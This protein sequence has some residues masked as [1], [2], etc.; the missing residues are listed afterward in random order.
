[1]SVWVRDTVTVTSV[2]L[3]ASGGG[4]FGA[5]VQR[6]SKRKTSSLKAWSSEE[7]RKL[8]LITV[9]A[10]VVANL[11]T[12][13]FV[14]LAIAIARNYPAHP[15]G[16][17]KDSGYLNEAIQVIFLW[18]LIYIVQYANKDASTAPK[19]PLSATRKKWLDQLNK[20]GPA[21]NRM[22]VY[23]KVLAGFLT[24]LYLFALVGSAAGIK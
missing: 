23:A 18:I 5:R 13:L 9:T 20:L 8:L 16:T 10:T 1:M 15:P 2:L 17:P 19:D 21:M 11:I 3:V 22:L 14:G 12:V 24:L 7:T 6:W 4:A